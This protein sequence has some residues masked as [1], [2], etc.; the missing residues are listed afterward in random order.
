MN[1]TKKKSLTSQIKA[2][3]KYHLSPIRLANNE[4]FYNIQY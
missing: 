3:M 2:F 4:V 1:I